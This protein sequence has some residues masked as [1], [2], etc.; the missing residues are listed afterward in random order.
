M[1]DIIHEIGIKASPDKIFQALTDTHQLSKWWTKET[2]GDANKIKGII[3]FRFNGDGPDF[4][5]VEL[6]PGKSVKWKSKDK[7]GGWVG[8]EIT[9]KIERDRSEDQTF[10]RFKHGKWKKSSNFM[11]HCSTKWA[12]FM[13]S[14]KSYLETGKGKP[15]PNDIPINHS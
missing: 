9:F 3:E 12:V 1:P 7:S 11:A 13:L 6:K 15:F 14:L 5:V 10:L 4:Q 8:T 2:I